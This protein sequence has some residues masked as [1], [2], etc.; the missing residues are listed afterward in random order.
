MKKKINQTAKTFIA[1][2]TSVW[3]RGVVHRPKDFTYKTIVGY[4]V[5]HAVSEKHCVQDPTG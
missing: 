1:N 5:D 4:Q 3:Y 2:E